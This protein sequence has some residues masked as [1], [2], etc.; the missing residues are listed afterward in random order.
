MNSDKEPTVEAVKQP[1]SE[2]SEMAKDL[3]G[4]MPGSAEEKR[5]VRKIDLYLM[6]ILWIKYVFNYIDRTNIV[7][8]IH[9]LAHD[10]G[11]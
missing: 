6:P 9:S 8:H 4:F 2:E 3:D 10:L 11:S 1:G 5:L 7:R